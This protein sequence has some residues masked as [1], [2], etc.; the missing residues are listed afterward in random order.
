VVGARLAFFK[1]RLSDQTRQV[2]LHLSKEGVAVA[3]V[4]RQP[5]GDTVTHQTFISTPNPLTAP[6]RVLEYLSTNGL[7]HLR[8][9]VVLSRNE[10]QLLLVEAPDVPDSEMKEA[11]IWRVKDFMNCAP[12]DAY[13]DYCPLPE[14]AYRG[15][16]SRVYVAVAQK[17]LID[18][19]AQ[20]MESLGLEPTWIDIPELSLLNLVE[21]LTEDEMGT[22][23]LALEHD[24]SHL[25][26][27]SLGQIYMAR[28]L[29]YSPH[30]QIDSTVLDVQRSMDYYESQIGKPPC[31]R[32]LVLPLQ[33][34]ETPLMMSLRNDLGADVQSLDLAD[35]IR[36]RDPLNVDTQQTCLFAIASALRP[37]E[38]A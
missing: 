8:A 18:A 4:A 16:G 7:A 32:I 19:R 35:V 14:D 5:D 26:M 20:W 30:S 36:S 1:K 6:E 10:Y 37:K 33:V 13:I 21:S 9:G 34:G 29:P 2:A 24:H 22:A 23:I 25:L 31:V 11:L 17:S 28:D 27:C 12:E 38:S 15:R 3:C